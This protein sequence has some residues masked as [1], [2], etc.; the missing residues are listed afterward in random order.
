[1]VIQNLTVLAEQR[2]ELEIMFEQKNFTVRDKNAEAQSRLVTLD[3]AAKS[4]SLEIPFVR[5]HVTGAVTEAG[6]LQNRYISR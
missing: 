3:Q 6:A 5:D 1:M 2:R 4:L